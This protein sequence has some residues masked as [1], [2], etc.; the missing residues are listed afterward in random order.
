[1]MAA[2]VQVDQ[3]RGKLDQQKGRLILSH[4]EA[5]LKKAG[6]HHINTLHRRGRLSD[7]ITEFENDADL[8]FIGKR[9]EQANP[10][11]EFLGANLEMV[12]RSVQKPLFLVSRYMRP[13][14]KFLIAYD[15]K[16]NANIAIAFCCSSPLLKGLECHLITIGNDPQTDTREAVKKLEQTG[17]TV[18]LHRET[19]GPISEIIQSYVENKEI[20]LLLMGAYS[21]SRVRTMLLGSTTAKLITACHVPMMLFRDTH[22]KIKPESMTV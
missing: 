3:E 12:A 21:H 10:E 18:V 20:D 16:E 11:S 4:A 6:V 17:Y 5:E 7:T 9:G 1:L 2:L 8:I 15:G 19:S 22:S 14:H 13:I